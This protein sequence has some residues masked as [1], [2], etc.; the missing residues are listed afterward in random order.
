MIRHIGTVAAL[1]A[2]MLT[3]G[4]NALSA[5]GIHNLVEGVDIPARGQSGLGGATEPVAPSC[6]AST[7][8]LTA[9]QAIYG[10]RS[11]SNTEVFVEEG[12]GEMWPG[13][14]TVRLN[15]RGP[16]PS[17]HLD[18]VNPEN[19]FPGLAEGDDRPAAQ[20]NFVG[21]V[22]EEIVGPYMHWAATQMWCATS[23]NGI[24][25]RGTFLRDGR[26]DV[27]TS[28]TLSA[29]PELVYTPQGELG[30]IGDVVPASGGDAEEQMR[31]YLDVGYGSRWE[32]YPSLDRIDFE[33]SPTYTTIRA[34]IFESA[35]D[36]ET[37]EAGGDV[38]YVSTLIGYPGLEG[39]IF[40]QM[41]QDNLYADR[42]EYE[43]HMARGGLAIDFGTYY[44]SPNGFRFDDG[45]VRQT[46][47]DTYGSIGANP[48]PIALDAGQHYFPPIV[49]IAYEERV[50]VCSE[51]S[52]FDCD[53]GEGDLVYE[54]GT[55]DVAEL[56]P[57]HYYFA[58]RML[59]A[60]SMNAMNSDSGAFDMEPFHRITER[61]PAG[62]RTGG[63]GGG[64]GGGGGGGGGGG[65]DD[66]DDDRDRH[67]T[68]ETSFARAPLM[69]AQA[70]DG[71]DW[72]GQDGGDGAGSDGGGSDS[73]SGTDGDPSLEPG[74]GV[75]AH[76]S[77]RPGSGPDGV[78]RP[79]LETN[80][81]VRCDFLLEEDKEVIE[82]G[83]RGN[84]IRVQSRDERW[85][86]R[87][88]G[89]CSPGEMDEE[90]EEERRYPDSIWVTP[91]ALFLETGELRYLE[92]VVRD[93]HGED[94]ETVS[95][96]FYSTNEA[97]AEVNTAGGVRGLLPGTGYIWIE[98][99][100]IRVRVPF[101]VED[102]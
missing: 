97:A 52:G 67:I 62:Q 4:P 75:R 89:N 2:F 8:R 37:F 18:T 82:E 24:T 79:D 50:Q 64:P 14:Q 31:D 96:N 99:G 63:G 101:Q 17:E 87:V 59:V 48:G 43:G 68:D 9:A 19:N 69:I 57:Q 7:T 94:M 26:V 92:V 21:T 60:D 72:D 76:M 5:Q 54:P 93:Q 70:Q 44:Q 38:E 58:P 6:G 27:E 30:R 83:D 73:G 35:E 45:T 3:I 40:R 11:L 28:Q 98:S 15:Y 22:P 33:L 34:R 49:E 20:F 86:C 1:A 36:R 78:Y 10:N 84:D 25:F 53:A 88:H 16:I 42:P 80:P 66:I 65:D 32:S 71:W 51:R 61:T 55:S 91:Q 41:Y 47:I 85:D 102:P 95:I 90:D 12:W 74:Y 13:L 77:Y 46:F 81:G 100:D 23:E 29:T 56:C 39:M